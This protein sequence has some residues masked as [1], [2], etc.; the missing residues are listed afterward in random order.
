MESEKSKKRRVIRASNLATQDQFLA[1]AFD[2]MLEC[3]NDNKRH[4]MKLLKKAVRRAK[5]DYE[6][7]FEDGDEV[8][9]IQSL[10]VLIGY[11]H[12]YDRIVQWEREG[13]CP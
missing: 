11:C 4:V 10:M 13:D 12:V 2:S 8:A 7:S 6:L 3:L 5:A 9:T 1:D